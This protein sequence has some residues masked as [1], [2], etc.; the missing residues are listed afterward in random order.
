MDA[1]TIK[2]LFKTTLLRSKNEYPLIVEFGENIGSLYIDDNID[3]FLKAIDKFI[4]NNGTFEELLEIF[5][6]YSSDFCKSAE[7]DAISIED[8]SEILFDDIIKNPTKVTDISFIAEQASAMSA[9]L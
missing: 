4:D 2:I 3:D 5:R 7:G 6:T 8:V 9:I 1:K